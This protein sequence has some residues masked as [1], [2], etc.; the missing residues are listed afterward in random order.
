MDQRSID[1]YDLPQRVASYDI[2]MEVLHPNRGKM[3]QVALEVLPFPGDAVLRALDLGIGTGYF[4]Q[5]FLDH[6]ANS[7]VI[8]VDGAQAMI[9]L[10]KARLENLNGKIDF[11]IADFRR[12]DQMGLGTER[13]D[14]IYSS[15]ALHHLN[16]EEKLALIAQAIDL[17][18][19]NGWFLN[20]DIFIADTPQV[21]Q[22]IQQLR[23]KGIVERASATDPRFQDA[24]ATRRFLDD[25]EEKDGDQPQTLLNDLQIIR[26]GGLLNASVLWL[27]YREAV[28]GGEK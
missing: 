27:E 10:A 13:F 17:L 11:R 14:V 25:L 19:T 16:R 26:S 23:I 28:F 1:A 15:Y 6:Y 24:L 22:R 12:L 20:A 4:T 3:I 9:E 8:A 2:D 18:R 5:R 7:R 21:E